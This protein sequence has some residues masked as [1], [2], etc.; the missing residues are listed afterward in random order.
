MSL[1]FFR[2][3]SLHFFNSL[4]HT[5]I[6]TYERMGRGGRSWGGQPIFSDNE[7]MFLGT[8]LWHAIA[9]PSC[10]C[11]TTR[12]FLL[13]LATNTHQHLPTPTNTRQ[14]HQHPNNT[15]KTLKTLTK[16]SHTTLKQN[17][18]NTRTTLIQ[19]SHNTHTSTTLTQHSNITHTTLIQH[20]C[21]THTT[22]TQ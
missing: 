17:S 5:L 19:H 22:R 2:F 16:H 8:H 10:L 12:F 6:I 21:N 4:F 13:F 20:S 7:T 9:H 15:R 1:R 18:H 14:H 11:F 3:V